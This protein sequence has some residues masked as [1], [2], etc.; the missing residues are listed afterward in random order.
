MV[1]ILESY[2]VD[3]P[4]VPGISPADLPFCPSW[5]ALSVMY[6]TDS[7]ESPFLTLRVCFGKVKSDTCSNQLITFARFFGETLTIK[8]RH[9]SAAAL[10]QTFAF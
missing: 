6:I 1:L 4:E 7:M 3:L 2:N 9:L 5:G 8:Y 10:N